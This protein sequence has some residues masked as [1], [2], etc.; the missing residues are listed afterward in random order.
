MLQ[1]A[2]D[3]SLPELRLVIQSTVFV[4]VRYALAT[5]TDLARIAGLTSNQG[6][7]TETIEHHLIQVGYRL[8]GISEQPQT[9]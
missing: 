2:V 5:Q 8:L 1:Q 6:H 4:I 7:I 9:P 3:M